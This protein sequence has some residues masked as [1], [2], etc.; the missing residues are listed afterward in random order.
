MQLWRGVG[1][2][3]IDYPA[4]LKASGVNCEDL[5]AK[6]DEFSST[7]P[8][9]S[10]ASRATTVVGQPKHAMEE[11]VES[12]GARLSKKRLYQIIKEELEKLSVEEGAMG[13][14]SNGIKE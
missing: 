7:A 9:Q 8:A 5:M 3:H 12:S 11:S 4:Q 6:Y 10:R 2:D 13:A 14:R 1:P